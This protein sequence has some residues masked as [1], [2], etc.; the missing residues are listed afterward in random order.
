MIEFLQ[1]NWSTLAIWVAI[2]TKYQ[3]LKIYYKGK[4][5]K[6]FSYPLPK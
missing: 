2:Y 3:K 5:I 4:L 1:A 6:A